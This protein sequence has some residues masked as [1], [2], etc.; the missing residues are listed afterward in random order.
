[1]IL[2]AQVF[3][4]LVSSVT[5]FFVLARS[6]WI[7]AHQPWIASHPALLMLGMGT[8]VLGVALGWQALE[9]ARLR[10]L[11][12]V[13]ET[14]LGARTWLRALLVAWLAQQLLGGL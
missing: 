4:A 10:R 2:L 7:R 11:A 1:M 9:E 12:S 3:I 14:A 13:S 8:L 5:F 6:P